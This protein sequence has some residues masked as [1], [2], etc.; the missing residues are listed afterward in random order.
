[1]P[2]IDFRT[3]SADELA[4]IEPGDFIAAVK[5]MSDR[6]LRDLMEGPN[7]APVVTSIFTRMPLI[8]RPERAGVASAT[9]HWSLTGL[10]DV[11]AGDWTVRVAEGQ[12]TVLRGHVGDATLALTMTPVDFIKLI[13]K[14]GN[15]VMMFMTGKL[16]AKGDIGLAASLASWFDV[17][18]P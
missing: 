7:A 3:A 14:T 17:P 12:C 6:D 2:E 13:T 18:R 1:M 8:F 5:R 9:T 10:P 16:R 4:A 11:G 15:P